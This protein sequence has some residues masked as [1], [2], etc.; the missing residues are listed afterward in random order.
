M[1][2]RNVGREGVVRKG[3]G[4]RGRSEREAD[5]DLHLGIKDGGSIWREQTRRIEKDKVARDTLT[6]AG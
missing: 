1:G 4:G 2:C 5:K 6:L 3:G